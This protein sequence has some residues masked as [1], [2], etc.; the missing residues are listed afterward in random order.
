MENILSLKE[1]AYKIVTALVYFLLAYYSAAILCNYVYRRNRKQKTLKERTL[2]VVFGSGG[3]TTEMLHMLKGLKVE[4]YGHVCFVI[5]HSDTWS[6][7]KLS[8]FMPEAE[9]SKV[10]L[11]RLYRAREVK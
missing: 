1:L 7:T 10:T 11:V 3:H 9:L 5:G 6:L 2:M 4:K 8:S